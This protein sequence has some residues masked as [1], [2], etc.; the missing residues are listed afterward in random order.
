MPSKLRAPTQSGEM[1]KVVQKIYDDINSLIDSLNLD[2]EGAKEPDE[3]SKSGSVCVVK[4]GNKYSLRGKTEDGWASVGIKLLNSPE[5][6]K[7]DISKKFNNADDLSSLDSI[8]SITDNTTGTAYTDDTIPDAD[9]AWSTTE[10]NNCIA[11]LAVK[12]NALIPII[13]TVNELV[14]MVN[15]HN[16][17][18]NTLIDKVNEL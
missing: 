7:L 16:D 4:E 8:T 6:S 2:L 10:M 18:I 12:I 15:T 9:S 3:K 13:S 5:V 14:T 11:Y 1:G 17:R